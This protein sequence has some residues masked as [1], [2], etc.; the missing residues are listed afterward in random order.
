[1]HHGKTFASFVALLLASGS[2]LALEN[3]A[4]MPDTPAGPSI[5]TEDVDRFY[6]VYDAAGGKPDAETLQR[7]YLDKGSEGL[8]QLAKVRNVTGARIADMLAKRPEIYADARRCMAVLP[9]VRE[10]VG[11]ALRT[12]L[13]RY[14]QARV[15]AVTIAVGRGK[16]VGVGSPSGGLQIG[17]E[18]LC[19]TNWLN[20]DVEDRFVYVIVHE[21]VHVQQN[22]ALSEA[23]HPTVL[24]RSLVEGAAEFVAKLVSGGVA[25]SHFG[26]LTKGHE[27][28]IERAFAA[29]MD[30]TDLS[31]WL[32]NSTSEKPRDLGYWVGYRIVRSY[33]EHEPDKRRAL[34]EI[35][36]MSDAKAFLTRSRWSPSGPPGESS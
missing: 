9:Q 18:A 6:A 11:A 23:E 25:Y 19:A 14:P 22:E 7:D 16:P 20:P 30:K 13:A 36:Q 31:Q 28:E 32:D 3:H 27:R 24:E 15:P 29:D 34:R 4:S 8:H 33:Y 21:Y 35:I 2:A 10:R 5:H 12:L 1:M 17:L 26:P